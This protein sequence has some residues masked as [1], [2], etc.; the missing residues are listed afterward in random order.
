MNFDWLVKELIK[1]G[2]KEQM[3]ISVGD[4]FNFKVIFHKSITNRFKSYCRL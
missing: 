3:K 2:I 4:I 1:S